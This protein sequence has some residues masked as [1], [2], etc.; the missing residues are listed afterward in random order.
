MKLTLALL[1][2]GRKLSHYI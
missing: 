2:M 1:I